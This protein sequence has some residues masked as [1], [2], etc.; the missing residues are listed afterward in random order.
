[1]VL[2]WYVQII[3][4]NQIKTMKLSIINKHDHCTWT[5]KK[6]T[7]KIKKMTKT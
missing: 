4:I 2:S 5:K 1:M 6:K 3:I 7:A